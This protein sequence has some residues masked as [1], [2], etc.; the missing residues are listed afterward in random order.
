MEG[1]RA[2]TQRGG[3]LRGCCSCVAFHTAS[4]KLRDERG[5]LGRGR[6]CAF[7]FPYNLTVQ[8]ETERATGGI[9]DSRW[10]VIRTNVL[11]RPGKG[12]SKGEQEKQKSQ[13]SRNWNLR[14][15]LAE[16]HLLKQLVQLP[17]F[18]PIR[19]GPTLSGSLLLFPPVPS[20]YLCFYPF[21]F[22]T[23]LILTGLCHFLYPKLF[24]LFS[25]L[26]LILKGEKQNSKV[27]QKQNSNRTV[28][29]LQLLLWYVLL[30]SKWPQACKVRQTT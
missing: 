16:L 30:S 9:S 29:N 12:W 14:G 8:I 21:V 1:P 10:L 7:F 4:E 26:F 25:F 19:S 5:R 22:L 24:F 28:G 23:L 18:T 13:A 2:K 6:F 27:K 20:A 17:I 15:S 3:G 11:R